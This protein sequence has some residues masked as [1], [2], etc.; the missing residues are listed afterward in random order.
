MAENKEMRA[1]PFLVISKVEI[2]LVLRRSPD[3]KNIN[4]QVEDS[5]EH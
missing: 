4:W 3:T 1:R 2:F 5:F